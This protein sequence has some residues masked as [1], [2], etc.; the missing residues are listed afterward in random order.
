[1]SRETII[2]AV[3]GTQFPLGKLSEA[4]AARANGGR[5][6]GGGKEKGA[7][8][9]K[10]TRMPPFSLGFQ[11][12]RDRC[13]LG[14]APCRLYP[15]RCRWKAIS[16]IARCLPVPRLYYLHGPIY[17]WYLDLSASIAKIDRSR[18]L[19]LSIQS[20]TLAAIN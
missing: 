17:D 6:R 4:E 12:D 15:P 10:G 1:M 13:F 2:F 16:Q 8:C 5:G 20:F 18:A 19:S 3:F 7:R 11:R 9:S 14:D